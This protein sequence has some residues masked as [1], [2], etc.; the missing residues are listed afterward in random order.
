MG[1]DGNLREQR[2]HEPLEKE[3]L[4]GRGIF[5]YGKIE[6]GREL[7]ATSDW[8]LFNINLQQLSSRLPSHCETERQ[9]KRKRKR[10][11]EVEIEV[12]RRMV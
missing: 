1:E 8:L 3:K 7:L 12:E 2:K 11:I 9:T 6:W 10:E 5:L 4:R